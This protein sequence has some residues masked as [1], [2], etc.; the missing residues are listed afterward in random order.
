MRFALDVLAWASFLAGGVFLVAGAIGVIRFPDFFSRMHAAGVTDTLGA[1]LIILGMILQ[2][3]MVLNTVKLV[4]ILIFIWFT[5]PVASHALGHAAIVKGLKPWK[6]GDR[7]A[8]PDT[9][10]EAP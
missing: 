3:D 10:S 2:S 6:K 8:P 7:I 4:T 9:G 5:S 1:G